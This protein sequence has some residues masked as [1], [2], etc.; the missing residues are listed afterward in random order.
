MLK[1]DTDVD[2][3]TLTVSAV[4]GG[5]VGVQ[6]GLASGAL[7][8]LNADGSYV[9]NPNGKFEALGVGENG[10]DSFSYTVSDGHGGTDTATV[11][12]TI[13]GVND[14][15][16]AV[17]DTGTTGENTTLTVNA[18]NGVL[19]N[20]TDIDGDTLTVSGV[21]GGTVGVQF[22]LASGA[23]LTLNA[24]GS[25]VYNPNGKFESLSAGV[26]GADS[27]TYTIS[28]G[29]TGTDTATVNLTI[30]G[31]ND[32]PIITS[33]G[34]GTV[35]DPISI[36]ENTTAVTTVTASDV[37][38]VHTLT[39]DLS[40]GSDKDFFTI[41]KNSGVLSFLNP[42][43]FEDKADSDN[44]GVYVVDVR[45]TDDKGAT[46]TQQISVTVEDVANETITGTSGADSLTGADGN[47]SI[48][49]LGGSDSLDGG[50]GLDSITGGAADDLI[51]GGDGADLLTGGDDGDTFDYNFITEAGDT[52]TDFL[53][54]LEGDTINIAD[55]LSG[56]L[57]PDDD[58]DTLG[59]VQIGGTTDAIIQVDVDG[60]GD[61]FIDLVTLQGVSASVTVDQLVADNNLVASGGA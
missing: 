31:V 58:L 16:V 33:D 15:P 10:A 47:D 41:D 4:T 24:D 59:F 35:A 45:V 37:D 51:T 13:T 22:A 36:D 54:G 57:G 43:D 61:N 39:Y 60:S 7:L 49:G 21:T 3:D 18:A 6:F 48:S 20:D 56:F 8:T 30:T 5:T 42:P 28:D 27:F 2:G 1:N 52:I 46:D 14:A 17:N 34:G 44:D 9:Y 12:L 26:N 11:N 55:L 32:A 50:A 53:T 23:L 25:Y 19:K 38:A 29:H 40:G